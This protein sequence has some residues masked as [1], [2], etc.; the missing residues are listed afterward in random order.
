M[1]FF[2]NYFLG[3]QAEELRATVVGFSS[4]SVTARPA[5]H[6][7]SFSSGDFIL[8]IVAQEK[9][10]IDRIG[11]VYWIEPSVGITLI[12]HRIVSMRGIV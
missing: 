11:D 4:E 6:V 8:D 10:G 7:L 1:V 3:I 2:I 9:V 12:R 5:L